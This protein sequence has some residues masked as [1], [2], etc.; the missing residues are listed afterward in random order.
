MRF[1]SLAS[2]E[3]STLVGVPFLVIQVLIYSFV[4]LDTLAVDQVFCFLLLFFKRRLELFPFKFLYERVVHD[5]WVNKIYS[6]S[7]YFMFA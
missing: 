4:I 1:I 5:K 3:S 6:F 2:L 7:R